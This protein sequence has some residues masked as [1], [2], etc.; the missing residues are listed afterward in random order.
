MY[1]LINIAVLFCVVATQINANPQWYLG[2]SSESC[3][4]TC[5]KVSKTCSLSTL[6]TVTTASAFESVVSSSNQLG[7]TETTGSV[8]EFCTGGVNSWPFATAPSVVQYPLYVKDPES[9]VGQYITTNNCFY[10]EG[11]ME[12]DCDSTYNVP[13][14]Q[15]FCPCE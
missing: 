1:F 8:A 9:G 4:E 13:P 12:G 6:Q 7:K 5:T 14:A 3:T 11:N 2:Y 10:P 15:R